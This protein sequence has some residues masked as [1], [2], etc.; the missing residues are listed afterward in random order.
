MKFRFL[1]H[2]KTV[3]RQTIDS[4]TAGTQIHENDHVTASTLRGGLLTNCNLRYL[5]WTNFGGEDILVNDDYKRQGLYIFDHTMYYNIYDKYIVGDYAQILLSP[6]NELSDELIEALIKQA[7]VDFNQLIN[8]RPVLALDTQEWR[9][10]LGSDP[11][12][13]QGKTPHHKLLA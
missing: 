4:Y 5:F 7:R 8:T 12:G 10:R 9:R 2:D 6:V 1:Y 13:K 3:S 11:I